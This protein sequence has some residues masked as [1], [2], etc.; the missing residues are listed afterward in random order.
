MRDCNGKL[1]SLGSATVFGGSCSDCRNILNGSALFDEC[2]VCGGHD[3]C[4]VEEKISVVPIGS[5][6]SLIVLISVSA[7][8]ILCVAFLYGFHR[9]M[10]IQDALHL[11]SQDFNGELCLGGSGVFFARRR[12]GHLFV[13]KPDGALQRGD[14]LERLGYKDLRKGCSAAEAKKWWLRCWL[15]RCNG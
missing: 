2:G 3:E 14:K 9:R 10:V 5:Y 7:V 8:G 11:L 13:S 1:R 6:I 12:D 15:T 4:R